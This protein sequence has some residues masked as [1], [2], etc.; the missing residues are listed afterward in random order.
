MFVNHSQ[1]AIILNCSKSMIYNLIQEDKKNIDIDI[2]IE[3]CNRS[4]FILVGKRF[5]D[6][7]LVNLKDFSYVEAKVVMQLLNI[8]YYELKKLRENKIIDYKKLTQT[9]S[10]YNVNSIIKNFP[11]VNMKVPLISKQ[12]YS[13]KEIQELLKT[14]NVDISIRTL[15][16]YIDNKKIPYILIG[17]TYRIPIIEFNI[18]MS[19]FY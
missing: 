14:K 15:Y 6:R 12:F 11:Q 2:F 7:L 5:S 8:N 13:I 3:S 16:R 4:K 9:Q 18:I 1:L 10:L 19:T 17:N